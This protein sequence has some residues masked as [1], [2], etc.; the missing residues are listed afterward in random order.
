MDYLLGR[1]D[2]R[3]DGFGSWPLISVLLQV[4]GIGRGRTMDGD[5]LRGITFIS[6]H[7]SK[8]GLTDVHRVIQHGLENRL[9][10]TRRTGDDAENL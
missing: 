3:R 4:F 9:E 7:K 2:A 10:A 5:N 6:I 1:G 8:F